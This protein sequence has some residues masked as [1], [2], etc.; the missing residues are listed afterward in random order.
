MGKAPYRLAISRDGI[1]VARIMVRPPD[2]GKLDV[3]FSF[4][5]R[6]YD[7]FAYPLHAINPL[8]CA[9]DR[10]TQTDITY[11]HGAGGRQVVIHVK[12]L[13]PM[14]GE[15]RYLDIPLSSIVAP[16][17]DTIMPLPLAKIEV[18]DELTRTQTAGKRR[19]KPGKLFFEMESDC[20]A[21]EIYLT[22]PTWP[23]GRHT[24]TFPELVSLLLTLPFETWS[25]GK[26]AVNESK[27]SPL[28][29]G[30]ASRVFT[31]VKMGDV[32]LLVM[33]YR[34]PH[35]PQPLRPRATFIDNALAEAM[36]LHAQYVPTGTGFAMSSAPNSDLIRLPAPMR[37]ND[38][39]DQSLWVRALRAGRVS[40]QAKERSA[41]LI[42]DKR[43][44]LVNSIKDHMRQ[45]T[46]IIDSM[47]RGAEAFHF[48][49]RPREGKRPWAFE[50]VNEHLRY[51]AEAIRPPALI[52]CTRLRHEERGIDRWYAFATKGDV[53]VHLNIEWL[54]G[55]AEV[56]GRPM[57]MMSEGRPFSD[58]LCAL[59]GVL[60]DKGFV[61]DNTVTQLLMPSEGEDEHDMRTAFLYAPKSHVAVMKEAG[62][63]IPEGIRVLMDDE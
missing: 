48:A 58:G 30:V 37:L 6:E 36:M 46:E 44:A 35:M 59:R 12:R 27:V 21:L 34:Q 7:A 13:Q 1:D 49:Y 19:K 25:A 42:D 33:Q 40:E 4:L 10:S 55:V 2:E 43:I 24:E 32:N 56:E 51:V 15:D 31:E 47:Q 3:I 41:K 60:M 9:F 38:L 52:H 63:E 29:H 61:C 53:D 14:E 18:P 11:H 26:T 22:N 28:A 45:Q 5:G 8:Y 62:W 50:S 39:R 16:S 57:A 20:T 23:L 54:C 17:T